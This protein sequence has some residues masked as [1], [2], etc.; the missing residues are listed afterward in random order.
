M[1]REYLASLFQK[2]LPK[3]PRYERRVTSNADWRGLEIWLVYRAILQVKKNYGNKL[4]YEIPYGKLNGPNHPRCVFVDNLCA[5][6][7]GGKEM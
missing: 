7:A 1:M 4:G 2:P 3:P 5:R 6:Y